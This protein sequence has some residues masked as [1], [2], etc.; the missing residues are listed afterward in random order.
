MDDQVVV[1]YE[2]SCA[3][4]VGIGL[5]DDEDEGPPDS[6][7]ILFFC[8]VDEVGSLVSSVLGFFTVVS[9]FLFGGGGGGPSGCLGSTFT[10]VSVV[11]DV[12]LAR[13]FGGG[14]GSTTLAHGGGGFVFCG[15]SS[16]ATEAG[17]FGGS[18][19][20]A[21]ICFGSVFF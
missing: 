2:L 8:H 12:A 15:F 16:L 4:G 11:P 1:V 18:F 5:A 7:T 10:V 6:A 17:R 13:C 3:G 20:L 21:G 9:V 14:F 19:F